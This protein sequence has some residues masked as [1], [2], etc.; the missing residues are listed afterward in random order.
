[1]GYDPIL[2]KRDYIIGAMTA[3]GEKHNMKFYYDYL[4]KGYELEG[5]LFDLNNKELSKWF[6]FDLAKIENVDKALNL[7]DFYLT[8]H[9]RDLEPRRFPYADLFE[10]YRKPRTA[11]SDHKNL[12]IKK[13]IFSD[14]CTIILWS[15]GTKTI[16]RTQGDDIYDPEK[17]MAMAICKKHLGGSGNY[18]DEFK[19][20]LPE[21]KVDNFKDSSLEALQFTS[22]KLHENFKEAV[23]DL[24][25]VL[26][27]RKD[28]LCRKLE[29]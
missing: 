8:K 2:S 22:K 9:R 4:A 1:M 14:P 23:D 21:E 16:V 11:M 29:L 25:R 19:K 7:I 28:N 12:T 17:G 15:D 24:T 5:V 27:E 6:S 13:V 3:I 18:Y 26:L 20:W 10:D